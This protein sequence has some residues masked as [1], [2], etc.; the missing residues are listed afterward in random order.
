MAKSGKNQ[1]SIAEALGIGGVQEPNIITAAESIGVDDVLNHVSVPSASSYTITL[2][3]IAEAA[4][5]I[6][7]FVCTADLGGTGVVVADRDDAIVAGKNYTTASNGLTAVG[8]YLILLCTG[9]NY[10]QL[11]ASLT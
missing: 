5:R 9:L 3:P 1:L 11:A 7:V 4:G 10:V 2:P 6:F 8:D